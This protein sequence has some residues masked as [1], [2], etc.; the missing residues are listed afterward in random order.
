MYIM[1]YLN[2]ERKR[3]FLIDYIILLTFF[4][5]YFLDIKLTQPIIVYLSLSDL[6]KVTI[7]FDKTQSK[8]RSILYI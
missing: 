8:V 3:D 1:L 5:K 4:T 6:Y 2:R 7:Y